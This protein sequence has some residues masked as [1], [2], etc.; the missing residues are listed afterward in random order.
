MYAC[1]AVVILSHKYHVYISAG[2]TLAV[3]DVRQFD[4]YEDGMISYRVLSA[5]SIILLVMAWY[6]QIVI[7]YCIIM[8]FYPPMNVLSYSC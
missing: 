8:V 3:E 2:K 5:S 4:T 6:N 7:A 1:S